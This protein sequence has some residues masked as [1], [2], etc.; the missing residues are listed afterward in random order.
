MHAPQSALLHPV[1]QMG[2]WEFAVKL[3]WKFHPSWRVTRLYTLRQLLSGFVW[4]AR[5]ASLAVCVEC[6]WGPQSQPPSSPGFLLM[7]GVTSTQLAPVITHDSSVLRFSPVRTSPKEL[8]ASCFFLCAPNIS[9]W[10]PAVRKTGGRG[11]GQ[12]PNTATTFSPPSHPVCVHSS[13]SSCP[14]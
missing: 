13:R 14:L 7:I 6:V 2:W 10:M 11:Q 12:T 3:N 4:R 1:S 5:D 9:C 8:T